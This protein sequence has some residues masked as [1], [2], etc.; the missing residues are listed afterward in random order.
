MSLS[1]FAK[2][3]KGIENSLNSIAKAKSE[4]PIED[5]NTGHVT[6]MFAPAPCTSIHPPECS[7]AGTSVQLKSMRTSLLE[8]T[9]ISKI[10]K[11]R[12]KSSRK[13]HPL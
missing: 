5:R 13:L 11:N 3:L 4:G 1:D 6:A 12:Q 10:G 9:E 2:M 8:A 7:S